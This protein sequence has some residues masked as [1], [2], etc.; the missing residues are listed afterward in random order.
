MGKKVR[1]FY[2]YLAAV[3]K[4]QWR[5]LSFVI[6]LLTLILLSL[7]FFAPI[8]NRSLAAFTSKAVKPVF[9]EGVVGNPRTFN[10]LFSRLEVEKEING[11][12]F[13]GLTK[14]S[15][16]GKI[17]PDLAESVEIKD[18]TN[19]IFKLRKNVSWQDGKQFS[20]D[21]VLYTIAVAQNPLY[22]STVAAN[23][24]DVQVAKIDD[25]TVSFKLKEPFAPFLTTTT[26]GIIP[27]HVSLTDYRP[28]GTGEFRFIQINEG[29][30]L[31]EN[32]AL[33]VRFQFYPNEEAAV[34]ALK[35]GE[36]HALSSSRE[37][38]PEVNP[39]KNY[40]V[41]TAALPYRLITLFYNTKEAP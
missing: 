13:R 7:S 40:K 26:L 15:P 35:L 23:L 11:L 33:R 10:P 16:E 38:L 14:V 37:K 17:E 1:F 2:H 41:E 31:L 6:A 3:F 20:A 12:V 24:R 27:Q 30:V 29:F 22:D 21:D 34:L 19:Y 36:V 8:L 25:Y 5:R 32:N 39:W 4:K 18:N 9:R 28:I